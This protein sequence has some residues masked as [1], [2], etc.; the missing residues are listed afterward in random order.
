MRS[1]SR[2]TPCL[3]IPIPLVRSLTAS[4]T[5]VKYIV[6]CFLWPTHPLLQPM[7]KIVGNIAY[8]ISTIYDDIHLLVF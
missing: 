8:Y 4:F 7:N 3:I 5:S 2:S 6:I 1:A